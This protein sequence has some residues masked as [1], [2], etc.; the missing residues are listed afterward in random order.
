V[1]EPEPEP[2][3]GPL[4]DFVVEPSSQPEPPPAPAPSALE[5]EEEED[6]GPLPDF[7][8]DPSLPPELRPPPPPRPDP[9]PEMA[10]K[11]TVEVATEPGA[12]STQPTSTELNFPSVTSFS[13]SGDRRVDRGDRRGSGGRRAAPPDPGQ[14]EALEP[15]RR[16]RRRGRRVRLDGGPLEPSERVQ[17]GRRGGAGTTPERPP[18]KRPTRPRKTDL[19]IACGG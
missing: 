1:P 8:I 4:P 9:K 14:G 16:A 10:L 18:S 6:L 2:E 17:P 7:V 3:V 12:D 5:A 15:T 19:R 11:L 13:I